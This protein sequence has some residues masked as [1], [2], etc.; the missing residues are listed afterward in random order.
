MRNKLKLTTFIL[1]LGLTLASHLFGQAAAMNGEITG[2]VSDPADAVISGATVQIVNSD[3]GFKQT[4]K[5]TEAG[6]YR[7]TVLP[8]GNYEL[9][10]EAPG[11]G[12]VKRAGV[13]LTAGA[14]ATVNVTMGVAGTATRVD[15]T[16]S[17]A[18][19]EPSRIDLGSTLSEN[20]TRNLPLV[21]RNPYNFILFQPNVS[22]RANT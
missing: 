15:V 20:M 16:A 9:S 19:T 5:T 7:F 11:F 4:A 1:G 2:T 21:S 18:I 6:L 12:P 13:T 22:G 14:I 10:V 3:T 8:L 17:A